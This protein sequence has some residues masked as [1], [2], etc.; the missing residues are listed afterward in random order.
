M[1]SRLEGIAV[2]VGKSALDTRGINIHVVT[3]PLYVDSSSVTSSFVNVGKAS[4]LHLKQ[5]K[6][7]AADTSF[8]ICQS[9]VAMKVDMVSFLFS[10][11]SV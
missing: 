11:H 7:S 1:L 4:L 3:H 5:I 8:C 6:V 2:L 10:V 9:R